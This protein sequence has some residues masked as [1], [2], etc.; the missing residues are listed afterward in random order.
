MNIERGISVPFSGI[1]GNPGQNIAIHK[2]NDVNYGP[3]SSSGS[4][5]IINKYPV[6]S[7]IWDGMPVTM[8]TD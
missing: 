2:T 3:F 1:F 8:Y 5:L 4:V 7:L 6:E